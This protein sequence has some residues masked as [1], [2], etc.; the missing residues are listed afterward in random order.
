MSCD[1]G[2][3]VLDAQP[4]YLKTLSKEMKAL[5]IFKEIL[6]KGEASSRI[7]TLMGRQNSKG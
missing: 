3:R 6:P 1:R 2:R 4:S 5:D 7:Y